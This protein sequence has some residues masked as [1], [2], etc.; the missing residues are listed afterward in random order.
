[1]IDRI[2]HYDI[3]RETNLSNPK[4]SA[5]RKLCANGTDVNTSF[6]PITQEEIEKIENT[7]KKAALQFF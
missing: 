6:T 5:D 7:K 3:T 4:W 1:M 2:T